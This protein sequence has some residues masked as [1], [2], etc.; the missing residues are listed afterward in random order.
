MTVKITLT[1]KGF[2]FAEP[3]DESDL[4]KC[5]HCG[6]CLNECPTYL[7][8]GLEM[9]SP[10]GRLW[11]MKGVAEGALPMS[12]EVVAHWQRCIQCR[13]CEAV[14][15]S[16][17]PF[18]RLMERTQAQVAQ[19]TKSKQSRG[20]RFLR[21]LMLRA[22]LPHRSLLYA[23]GRLT[24]AYQKSGGQWLARK[25]CIVGLLPS[26]MQAAEAQLPA[27]PNAFFHP[28][29]RVTK[30]HGT[31]R[32]RV[33]LLSGCVMPIAYG[34]TM[35]AAVRVLTRNGCD[36]VLPPNQ[37]CCG[38]LH[39]HTGD[40][41][42]AKELA[43]R[44]IQAFLATNVEKVITASAGCGST[45][46][47]YADLFRDEPL[48]RA[49]AEKL[50]AMTVDITEFL[51]SLPLDAPRAR[52]DVKVTYQ[53]SC[54]LAHAQRITRA[55]R[56]VLAAIPGVE[57]IE[58]KNSARCCGAGGAYNLLQPDLSEAVLADKMDSVQAA[59]A[60]VV[61]TA[62]PGCMMQLGKGLRQRGLPGRVCHVVDLL[63]EAYQREQ[64]RDNRQGSYGAQSLGVHSRPRVN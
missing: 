52:L 49:Q 48:K 42:M 5:V 57:L 2:P 44:N 4:Y 43:W 6:L 51:A 26:G 46:R 36:V 22:L 23:A 9:E 28:S 39:G 13:A 35:R 24:W 12:P 27:L 55:P 64:L 37:T 38:A 59:K 18:G 63:D 29:P 8:T 14:C 56:Q 41:A 10:R 45:M 50:A 25:S 3:P 30:A 1:P 47:E 31:R 58:M 62:N 15:P 33:A 11:L 19:A 34:P 7:A 32:M 54:H 21:W 53:D 60:N 20:P 17:V 61:C 40:R 16:G